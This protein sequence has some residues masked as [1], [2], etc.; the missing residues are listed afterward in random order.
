MGAGGSRYGAGRPGWRRK[1]E[2]LVSLDVRLLHRWGL[3][4]TGTS[5][6]WKWSRGGEPSG[7][8]LVRI[9][10]DRLELIYQWTPSGGERQAR[11]TDFWLSHTNCHFGGV[12]HWVRCKWCGRRCAIIY[13]VSSD[14]YF[15]CRRCLRLGYSSEA[16]DLIGRLWRKQNKLEARLGEDCQKPKWMR[17]R[18]YESIWTKINEVEERK[19]HAFCVGA[20]ALLRRGG[21]TLEE[22]YG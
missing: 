4:R 22:L 15:A 7:S 10:S 14:G 20:L 6:P 21:M 3:L 13:G 5:F 8:V 9:E 11:S 2:H 16:E 12:R 1:C 19:D 18:T 17:T